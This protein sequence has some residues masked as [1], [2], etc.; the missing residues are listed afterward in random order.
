LKTAT[1]AVGA[2]IAPTFV[3]GANGNVTITSFTAAAAT[4]TTDASTYTCTFAGA[5]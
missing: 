3:A 1:T 5:K 4:A 2:N